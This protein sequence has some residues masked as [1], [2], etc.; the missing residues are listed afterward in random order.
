MIWNAEVYAQLL[1]KSH[2]QIRNSD[3]SG[4]FRQSL[5]PVKDNYNINKIHGLWHSHDECNVKENIQYCRLHITIHSHSASLLWHMSSHRGWSRYSIFRCCSSPG[6]VSA[7]E[8]LREAAVDRESQNIS[9]RAC[10]NLLHG[11]VVRALIW[12]S[13]ILRAV[14]VSKSWNVF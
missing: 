2:S 10:L 5:L 8:N 6:S 4:S 11:S 9:S 1:F 12:E 7:W 14:S 3:Q 13:D